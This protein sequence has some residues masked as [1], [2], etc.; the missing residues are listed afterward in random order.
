MMAIESLAAY[1]FGPSISAEQPQDGRVSKP[2][3]I[4]T[5]KSEVTR[6]I[7]LPLLK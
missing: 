2:S 1:R 3:N 6:A 7:E 5:G 4:K